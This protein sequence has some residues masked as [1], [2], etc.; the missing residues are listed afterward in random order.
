[1]AKRR[2]KSEIRDE[3]SRLAKCW[4]IARE[5][6]GHL[7]K[8]DGA[9]DQI[10]DDLPTSASLI[11]QFD[12]GKNPPS[13]LLAGLEQGLMDSAPALVMHAK[14]GAIAQNLL[15][16]YKEETGNDFLLD[17]TDYKSKARKAV[18]RGKIKSETEFYA[19]KEVI[20]DKDQTLFVDDQIS[21][22]FSL[23]EHF[24]LGQT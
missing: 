15:A 6:Q 7:L 9:P 18:E 24:E 14:L 17:C 16:R 5:F 11:A 10:I 2:T 13:Q 23:L 21:T 12:D 3:Y 19:L 22:A 20:S 4:E 1:M 8:A